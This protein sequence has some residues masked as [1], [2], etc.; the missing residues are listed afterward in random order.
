MKR[1]EFTEWL[2]NNNYDVG[3]INSRIANCLRIEDYEGNL[4]YH[5]K[6]D[7]MRELLKRLEYSKSD[8]YNNENSRHS[9]PINGDIY[10]GT[11]TFRSAVKLYMRFLCGENR[12]Q[13]KTIIKKIDK[14]KT[15][16]C[17]IEIRDSYM[18]FIKQFNISKKDLYNFGLEETILPNCDLVLKSWNELKRKLFNGDEIYI[19]CAGRNGNGTAI[20]LEFYKYLFKKSNILKDPTNNYIPQKL[21][22]DLTGFKRNKNVYNYQVSHIFGRTK[23]PLLFGAAWNIALVPKIIDPFTGHETKGEWPKEYQKLFLKMIKKRYR[24]FIQEYN[25]IIFNLKIDSNLDNFLKGLEKNRYS[26][27][28]IEQFKKG[29]KSEMAYIY[30]DNID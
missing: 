2:E 13:K 15:Y 1:L 11:A 27:K 21:I 20:Y 26:I 4:D 19:R 28:E 12:I 8:K 23:N 29:I 18:K 22:E 7:K 5:F 16:N 3:T 24:I 6:V 10:N 9:I 14:P 25:E 17:N 30:L